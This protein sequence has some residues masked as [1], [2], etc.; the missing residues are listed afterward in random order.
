V[1]VFAARS[2]IAGVPG[3]TAASEEETE[4]EEVMPTLDECKAAIRRLSIE[5]RAALIVW[6]SHGMPKDERK[7]VSAPAADMSPEEGRRLT[8]EAGRVGTSRLRE[9]MRSLA[10]VEDEIERRRTRIKLNDP[11]PPPPLIME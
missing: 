8:D 2:S 3:R 11:P 9:S 10:E 6:L 5:D 7:D 4:G 1:P